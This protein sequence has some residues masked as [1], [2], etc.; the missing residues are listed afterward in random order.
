MLTVFQMTASKCF[1]IPRS[2]LSVL[3]VHSSPTITSPS[4]LNNVI[5]FDAV[6]KLQLGERER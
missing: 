4:L 1:T 2:T 5:A 3:F 6:S